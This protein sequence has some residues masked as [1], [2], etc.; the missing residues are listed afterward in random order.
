[1]AMVKRDRNGRVNFGKLEYVIQALIVLSM[2]SFAIE[3]LPGL[4]ERTQRLLRVFEVICVVVFTVEYLLRILLCRPRFRYV[5]S[6]FGV[7][8]L[9]AILPFYLATGLDL[10]SL[11]AFRLLRLFRVLKLARYSAAVQRF[12]RA[13]IIA[14][15]E[16]VLFGAVTAI[17]LYLSSVGIYYFENSDQPEAF[18]SVFDS[19]WWAVCTLTTVGYGDVCPVTTGG[20]VFTVLV[21]LCGLGIVAVPTGLVA[22]ALSKAR[23]EEAERNV[24]AESNEPEDSD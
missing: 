9:M 6:F 1:M 15:E 18:G 13:F 11:R 20:K 17:V 2:V 16:L 23:R 5:L 22:S 14:R 24:D 3:T 4:Q 21:L 12:H 19:M 7:I 10:R 8:D